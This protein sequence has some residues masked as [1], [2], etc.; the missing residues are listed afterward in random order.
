MSVAHETP[1]TTPLPATNVTA[2][3]KPLTNVIAPRPTT[4]RG[5]VPSFIV[6]RLEEDLAPM[7]DV[8]AWLGGRDWLVH[9]AGN[10]SM[11]YLTVKRTF[12]I[13]GALLLLTAFAPLMLVVFAVLTITTGGRPIFRQQRVG[14]CGRLFSMY[15]FRTMRLDAHKLQAQVQNEKDGPIFKNR[16]DPRITTLG[17]YLRSFSIDELPQLFNILFGH[18][19]LVGPRP[20]V[21]SEVTQYRAWQFG[22][23]AVKP[24]LTCLWQISGRSEIGFEDWVRM[25]LWYVEHQNLWTD[26]KML[27]GT[28][29]S[30]LSRRGAY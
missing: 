6:P 7:P 23:L 3:P 25:D 14:H 4:S 13:V 28:P 20:P 24:G 27:V 5:S 29:L 16:R 22:R 15:K 8:G 9:P 10:R 1:A 30:V 18:M 19:G 21:V 2:G 11:V 26:L 17:R 12:D